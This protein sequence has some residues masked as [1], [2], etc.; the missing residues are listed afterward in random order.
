[1]YVIVF[2]NVVLIA[3]TVPFI[4]FTAPLHVIG[5]QLGCVPVNVPFAWHVRMAL[6]PES[7]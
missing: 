7:M 6:P 4:G 2:P 3:L 1:M 5:A